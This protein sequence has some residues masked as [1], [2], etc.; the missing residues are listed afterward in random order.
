M[1]LN[2]QRLP[3]FPGLHG[4]RQALEYGVKI[5]G[6]T[7]HFVDEGLVPDPSS[8]RRRFQFWT[9]MR[10]CLMNE[11]LFRNPLRSLKRLLCSV[12]T[13]WWYPAVM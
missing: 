8:C 9:M 5:A 10:K 4:Q 1:R 2:G 13:G 12:P 11:F 3:V 7:V 6:Y